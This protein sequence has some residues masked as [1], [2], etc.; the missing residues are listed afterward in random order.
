MVTECKAALTGSFYQAFRK[1]NS[2]SYFMSHPCLFFWW[3][4]VFLVYLK[5]H[6]PQNRHNQIKILQKVLLYKSI[7]KLDIELL[8]QTTDDLSN[9]AYWVLKC[10][11]NNS[12]W[13]TL[14]AHVILNTDLSK[15]FSTGIIKNF[16]CRYIRLYICFGSTFINCF[17]GVLW[18]E[19]A[20]QF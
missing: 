16:Q 2:D 13:I 5:S 17:D 11:L 14:R 3:L 7:R 12:I 19:Q 8:A 1:S 15:I 20:N 10:W 18:C 6:C 9:L 4:R